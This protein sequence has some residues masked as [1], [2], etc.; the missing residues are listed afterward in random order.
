MA[1]RAR[2]RE[3][4]ENLKIRFDLDSKIVQ[5]PNRDYLFR[6]V[7]AKSKWSKILAELAEEQT[8][9]N[10]KD[11][12]KDANP[13]IDGKDYV[14]ALHDV[15]SVMLNLQYRCHWDDLDVPSKIIEDDDQRQFVWGK[16][17]KKRKS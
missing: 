12:A 16:G 8:W 4:L 3:H 14:R 9:S 11:A 7:I 5:L 1:V 15:W 13:S 10:F 2:V 17:K 6:I